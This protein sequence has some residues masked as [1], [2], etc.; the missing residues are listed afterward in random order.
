MV[1]TVATMRRSHERRAS[2]VRYLDVTAV[3]LPFFAK[4]KRKEQSCHFSLKISSEIFRERATYEGKVMRIIRD[5]QSCAPMSNIVL[6]C[7]F[8]S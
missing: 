2:G 5:L 3:V 4:A 6:R 8:K 1:S 7:I